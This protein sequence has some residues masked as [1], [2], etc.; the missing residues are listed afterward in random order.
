MNINSFLSRPFHFPIPRLTI[1][2]LIALACSAPAVCGEIHDVAEKGDLQKV[3]ALLKDNPKLV[4][5]KDNWG[6]TPRS[7]GGILQ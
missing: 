2:T 5:S 3:R 7:L 6:A 1:V 4:S